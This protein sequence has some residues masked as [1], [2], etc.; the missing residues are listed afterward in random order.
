MLYKGFCFFLHRKIYILLMS[1]YIMGKEDHFDAEGRPTSLEGIASRIK[2]SLALVSGEEVITCRVEQSPADTLGGKQVTRHYE[3]EGVSVSSEQGKY[4]RDELKEIES[5]TREAIS[6]HFG[7][8]HYL[9]RQEGTGP[10]RFTITP[11]RKTNTPRRK[12]NYDWEKE[13]EEMHGPDGS[14][15]VAWSS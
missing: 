6:S 2:N 1:S 9:I 11:R 4:D 12:T 5:D 8:R 15:R 7:G 10:Y 3:W 13:V 14:R